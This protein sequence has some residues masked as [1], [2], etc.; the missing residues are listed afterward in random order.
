MCC[1]VRCVI[2]HLKASLSLQRGLKLS[3]YC[4]CLLFSVLARNKGVNVGSKGTDQVAAVCVCV[5][6]Q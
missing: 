6:V 1:G 2:L 5:C 4:S 3:E